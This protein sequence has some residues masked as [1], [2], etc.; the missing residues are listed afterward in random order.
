VLL[1]TPPQ[2]LAAGQHAVVG[3]RE[4]K[5]RQEG[6]SLPAAGAQTATDPDPIVVFIVRLLAAVSVANDRIT[7]T[8]RAS[9]Q[10]ELTAVC[11]PISFQLV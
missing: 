3:V 11:G 8:N 9:P 2:R 10:D 5:R 7:F 4:R 6:E 1:E